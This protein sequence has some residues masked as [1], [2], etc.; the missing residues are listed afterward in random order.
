MKVYLFGAVSTPGCMDYS[1]KY[2]A[3]ENRH[4]HPVGSQFVAR[5]FYVDDGVTS[6]DTV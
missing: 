2:L 6:S 3:N 4:S 5:D 1:L